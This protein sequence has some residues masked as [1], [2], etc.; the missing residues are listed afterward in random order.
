MRQ[1][2][3]RRP[4]K[5]TAFGAGRPRTAHARAGLIGLSRMALSIDVEG[6]VEYL[7]SNFVNGIK[8]LPAR[9]A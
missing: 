2:C 5:L 1:R 9:I 8:R 6:P 7:R 3:N 4:V